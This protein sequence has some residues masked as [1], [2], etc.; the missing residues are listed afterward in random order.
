MAGST[1]T[2]MYS[3]SGD[4]CVLARR[5]Q[6]QQREQIFERVFASLAAFCLSDRV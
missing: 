4:E 6:K 2:W 5:K 1:R 3:G